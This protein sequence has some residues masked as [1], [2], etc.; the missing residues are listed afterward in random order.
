MALRIDSGWQGKG[1][2]ELSLKKSS[3]VYAIYN[4]LNKNCSYRTDTINNGKL[5]ITHFDS[6]KRI[7]SG[8]FH[9]TVAKK[10]CDTIKVTEGRFDIQD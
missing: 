2:H 5:T 6:A 1:N 10:G 3:H 4:D 8:R 9:F 7:V